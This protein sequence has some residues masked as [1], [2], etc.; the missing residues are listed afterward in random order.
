MMR[1]KRRLT[2]GKRYFPKRGHGLTIAQH[3][4]EFCRLNSLRGD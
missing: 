4:A 1:A 2:A 3:V